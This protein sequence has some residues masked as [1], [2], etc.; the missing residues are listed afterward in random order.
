MKTPTTVNADGQYT[1]PFLQPGK[2]SVS[3]TQAGFPELHAAVS[4]SSLATRSRSIFR[5]RSVLTTTQVNVSADATLL[6]TQSSTAGQV[7]TPEEVENLPAN[8]RS[9]LGLAKTE[10][11]VV[12]KQKNSVVQARPFDNS[13][14]SDFS[15]GGGASQSNEYLAQWDSQRC[16]TPA[17][18]SGFSPLQD[19]VSE[20]RVDA[21]QADASYGDTSEW[22]DQPDC[23]VWWQPFSW[24][25]VRVQS[26]F[27]DQCASTDGFS[28]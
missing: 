24:N 12:P 20:I 14:A 16:K 19:A 26:I 22:N 1:I 3:A 2:Y 5:C 23:E 25:A 8:G 28:P 13:A 10:Y 9:P 7:L 17:V 6:Q 21:F 18:F 11:A 15:V 4:L 27:R